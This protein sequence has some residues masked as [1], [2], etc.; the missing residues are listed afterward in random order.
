MLLSV[1]DLKTDEDIEW[2]EMGDYRGIKHRFSL[3]DPTITRIR[4]LTHHVIIY[5]DKSTGYK[6]RKLVLNKYPMIQ[7]GVIR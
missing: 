6:R 1:K 2:I 3:G 5:Y 4:K 7:A